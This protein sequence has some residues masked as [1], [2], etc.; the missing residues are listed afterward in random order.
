MIVEQEYGDDDDIA[1]RRKEKQTEDI[2][3][4]TFEASLK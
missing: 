1:A 2:I 4:R 3:A